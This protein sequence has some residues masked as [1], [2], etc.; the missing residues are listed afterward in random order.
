MLK[1]G[2]KS[3][4]SEGQQKAVMKDVVLISFHYYNRI[5]EMLTL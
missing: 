4:N 1:V 5:S 3:N 2:K